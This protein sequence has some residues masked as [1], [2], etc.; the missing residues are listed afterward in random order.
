LA[1]VPAD[2]Y[3]HCRVVQLDLASGRPVAE[4]A[5]Q[6]EPAGIN[7][8]HHPDGWVGLS[9]G[10]GQD[11]TR[12]WWIRAPAVADGHLELLDAGWDDWVFSDVHKSGRQII[13]TPHGRGPLLVRSFPSLDPLR[14]VETRPT[15]RVGTSR[16]A[17]PET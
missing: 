2:S 16:R 8:I 13:T 10:E 1:V 17:S 6:G 9:E 11:A 12:A 14:E 7:P 5:I 3:D 4:A 15:T